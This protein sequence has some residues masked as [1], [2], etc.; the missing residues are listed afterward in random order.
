MQISKL[1]KPELIKLEMKTKVEFPADSPIHPQKRMILTKNEILKE[2][3]DLLDKSGKVVNKK[4]LLLDFFN[5]EKKA[6]TGI[7]QG[8]AIPHIRSM[9]AREF[10]LG[11]ARSKLGYEFDSL[12]KKAVHLFFVMAAPPY[13]DKLYLKIFK[14]LAE[15][16]QYDYFIQKLLEVSTE[17]EVIRT[18]EE[19]E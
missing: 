11:F 16:L 4:K 2:L 9:Q 12:D 5:R 6:T 19:M 18:I 8:I 15:M 1:L 13:E 14:A 7:G 17:Y 10:I 3:V